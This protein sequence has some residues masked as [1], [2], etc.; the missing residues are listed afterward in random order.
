LAKLDSGS[1]KSIKT[2]D[3]QSIYTSEELIKSLARLIDFY[4]P[5]EI[6]TQANLEDQ[7]YPDHSDHMAAGRFT[8][9]AYGEYIA[10]KGLDQTLLPIKFYIG[11]PV[12]ALEPNVSGEDLHGK[13][14]AFF[15]YAQFD[16]AVCR[17]E[18]ECSKNLALKKYLERQY[19]NAY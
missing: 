10:Q 19:Q 1:I 3:N 15:A 11:Y 2:V 6:R 8:Q 7:S 17:S 16:P 4:Q 5:W 13:E 14:T 18:V 12:Q 9:K